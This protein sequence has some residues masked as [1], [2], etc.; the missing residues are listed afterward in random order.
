MLAHRFCG[1]PDSVQPVQE[2][3]SL[4]MVRTGSAAWEL[5]TAITVPVGAEPIVRLAVRRV[6]SWHGTVLLTSTDRRPA[7]TAG[8]TTRLSRRR[9]RLGRGGSPPVPVSAVTCQAGWRRQSTAARD[10][11]V[12]PGLQSGGAKC[13]HVHIRS[14]GQAPR[15]AATGGRCF[16]R[17]IS[18]LHFCACLITYFHSQSQVTRIRQ[19]PARPCDMSNADRAT[20]MHRMWLPPRCVDADGLERRVTNVRERPLADS[21]ACAGLDQVLGCPSGARDTCAA[22]RGTPA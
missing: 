10:A 13:R 5:G 3:F 19:G 21:V 7:V 2:R 20:A 15:H 4:R 1:V 8:W 6:I 16:T 17:H 11:M 12:N 9:R 22:D 18:H 14:E